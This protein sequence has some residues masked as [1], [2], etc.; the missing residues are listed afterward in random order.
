MDAIS[1]VLIKEIGPRKIRVN[2]INPRIV[3]TEGTHT[4]GI[5][6]SDFD[7]T[8]VAQTPRGSARRRG[9]RGGVP[10]VERFAVVDWGAACDVGRDAVGGI[11]DGG[12]GSEVAHAPPALTGRL[13]TAR[14]SSYPE[15]PLPCSDPTTP[16]ANL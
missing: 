5:M 2:S 7:T 10:G 8:A 3:E 6:G 1:G 12:C 14:A 16:L 13:T 15:V 4:H 9:G 11:L